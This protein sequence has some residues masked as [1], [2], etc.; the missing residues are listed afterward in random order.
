MD[1]GEQRPPWFL[2]RYYGTLA[3][4]YS[5]V[6][7]TMRRNHLCVVVEADITVVIIMG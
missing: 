2:S 6:Q 7:M 4:R 1:R 5:G 3:L